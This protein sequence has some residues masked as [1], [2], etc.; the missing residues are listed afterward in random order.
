MP[1]PGAT[2]RILFDEI[3]TRS[4]LST[5]HIAVEA[6]SPDAITAFVADT[7]LLGWSPKLL[8]AQAIDAGSVVMLSIAELSITRRFAAYRRRKGSVS[9]AAREFLKV[10]PIMV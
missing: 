2:P 6:A 9:A 8:I 5:R 1:G 4:A 3:V 7:A 10:L